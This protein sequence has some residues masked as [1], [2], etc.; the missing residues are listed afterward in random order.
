[1]CT[2]CH[3]LPKGWN[4]KPTAFVGTSHWAMRQPIQQKRVADH[5]KRSSYFQPMR[6][7]YGPSL[8]YS[9]HHTVNVLFEKNRFCARLGMY[10]TTSRGSIV[11]PKN[12]SQ[13][14]LPTLLRHALQMK[15]VCKYVLY[16]VD[17]AH[18]LFLTVPSPLVA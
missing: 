15:I 10:S 3:S 1:M 13:R 4:A 5:G 9:F 6:A 8:R 7:T 11:A 17:R 16:I 18:A 12:G 2:S 14:A